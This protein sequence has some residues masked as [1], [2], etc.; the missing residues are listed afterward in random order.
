MLSTVKISKSKPPSKK[1]RKVRQSRVP[2]NGIGGGGRNIAQSPLMHVFRPRLFVKVRSF[3]C[4]GKQNETRSGKV[5]WS[6]VPDVDGPESQPGGRRNPCGKSV[7]LRKWADTVIRFLASAGR[8]LRGGD[9]PRSR[10]PLAGGRNAA[11]D[12]HHIC[13]AVGV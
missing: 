12:F 7:A 1:S 9:V 5:R 13:R 10:R 3:P 11:T 2:K 8:G 4:S 6:R